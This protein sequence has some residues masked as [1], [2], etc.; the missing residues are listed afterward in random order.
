[1]HMFEKFE[2]MSLLC[3]KIMWFT[4]NDTKTM[5]KNT[6]CARQMWFF[7]FYYANIC[8]HE[9][10]KY[11]TRLWGKIDLIGTN[12]VVTSLCFFCS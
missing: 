12:F 4:N 2:S 6:K 11:M 8:K 1:M 3:D 5:N 7:F 9:H 10:E